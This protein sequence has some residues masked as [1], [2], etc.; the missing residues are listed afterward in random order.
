L[1]ITVVNKEYLRRGDLKIKLLGRGFAWLDTGTLDSILDAGNFVATVE[2]RQGLKMACIEEVAYRMGFIDSNQVKKMAHNLMKS[3]YGQYL[4]D[5][6]NYE[7]RG[8][9]RK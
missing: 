1:E 3:G 7:V 9:K 2:K 4:L 6:L 5:M 8:V